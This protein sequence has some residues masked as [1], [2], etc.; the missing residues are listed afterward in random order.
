MP[1]ARIYDFHAIVDVVNGTEPWWQALR[2]NRQLLGE[3][4][5]QV[6]SIKSVVGMRYSTLKSPRIELEVTIL[7]G[8]FSERFA[9]DLRAN[10]KAIGEGLTQIMVDEATPMRPPPLPRVILK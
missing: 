10:V 7:Q 2:S 8:G 5:A 3:F 1:L 6:A 4:L 9:K